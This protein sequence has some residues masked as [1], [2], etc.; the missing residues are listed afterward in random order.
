[1][2]TRLDIHID[3]K[4]ERRF[5]IKFVRKKGDISKKIEELMKE[6]L[7]NQGKVK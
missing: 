4:I 2:K 1:M 5:R 6:S 7:K 3:S